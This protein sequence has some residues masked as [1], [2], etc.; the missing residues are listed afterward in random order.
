M[1]VTSGYVLEPPRVGGSNSTLTQTPNDLVSN[2][3]AFSASY[4]TSETVPRT[5]YMVLVM[6]DGKLPSAKFG[7][8]RNEG[9]LPLAP[10]VQ[11]FDYDARRQRFFPLPG[12]KPITVGVLSSN[13]N[14]QRL[15]VPVP[16][17][18]S[19]TAPVRLFFGSVGSG[20]TQ[21]VTLVESFGSPP[22]GTTEILTFGPNTGQ[23]NWNASDLITLGGLTVFFQQQ[24][25][26]SFSASNGNL[27]LLGNNTLL[28]N[29]IPGDTQYPLLRIGFGLWFQAVERSDD[30]HLSVNPASG[31][32]EWSAST[33]LL[34]FNAGDIT[35]NAGATVYYDGILIGANLSLPRQS[36]G[37]VNSQNNTSPQPI[38]I[39]NTPAVGGDVIFLIPGVIQFAQSVAV[40]VASFDSVGK[41]G[42]VQY[43]PTTGQ[44]ILSLADRTAYAGQPLQVVFGDLPIERGVSMRFFRTPIDLSG[45]N[46]T[47]KDVSCI[48]S[49]QSAVWQS[50]IIAMS[51]VAL[52]SVPIEDASFPVVVR[53]TQGTGSF[54]GTLPN[55][56]TVNP[57]AGLGYVFDFPNGQLDYAQRSNN[58][59]IPIQQSSSAVLLPNPLVVDSQ[60]SFGLETSPGSGLFFPFT[61]TPP[62][63]GVFTSGTG[64]GGLLNTTAGQFSF[65]QVVGVLLADGS[66]GS[67]SGASFSDP[68]QNFVAD[69]VQPGNAL[70]ALSGSSKGVYTVSGVSPT[71]LT[72][73]LPGGTTSS[74]PYEVVQGAEVLADRFFSQVELVD[75]N[76]RVEIIQSL[77][78]ISNAPRLS[79]QTSLVGSLRIRFGKGPLSTFS[80]AVNLVSN[81]GSFTT[82]S[83]LS[84]GVVEASISTGNL[85]FSSSDLVTGV[86]VYSVVRLVQDKD[87]TL[88]PALG[89]IS[90][91]QRFL[92]LQEGLVTYVSSEGPATPLVEPATFLVRKELAQPH[93][94]P[95]STVTFNPLGRTVFKVTGVFRGGRP[96]VI[97][98]QCI[99]DTAHATVTF[100]PDSQITNAL[101]HGATVQPNENIYIDYLILEAIGGENVLTVQNPPMSVATV[102]I[103]SGQSSFSISGNWVSSFIPG[104]LLRIEKEQVYILGSSTFDGPSNTTTVSIGGGETFTD[105]FSNPDLFVTSGLIRTSG[106]ALQP[107]YF[108]TEPSSYAPISRGMNTILLAGNRTSTYRTGSIL[109]FTDLAASF[110]DFY[111]STGVSFNATT[112]QTQ[113]TISRNTVRQYDTQ[114]LKFSIRPIIEASTSTVSTTLTPVQSQSL[115]VWRRTEGQIGTILS[116]PSDYTIDS[117]GNVTFGVPLQVNEALVIAYTGSIFVQG[118]L[119]FQASYTSLAAPSS[120][121]GLLNQSLTADY[122][123]F[124]PDSFYFRVESM[125]NFENEVSAD[126]QSQALQ[127]V[128]SGGPLLS[129]TSQPQLFQQGKPSIFF[130]EGHLAN[131]DTIARVVLKIYNDSINSLEGF[132]NNIDGRI[133]G[134]VDGAFSFD[135]VV[136]RV[137][138]GFPPTSIF[139]EIDDLIQV[140]PFPLPGGTFQQV[141]LPGPYSRFFP[142]RRNL[143]T[144]SP[145][146]A[147]V[148]NGDQIAK[149]TF[150]A[151]SSLPFSAFRRWPRAQIQASYPAGTST[152]LVDNATGTNDA[153]QRP[154][155]VNSMRV[156]V[157]DRSGNIYVA[158]AA[159]VTV[160]SFTATSITLS[161]PVGV[162]VPA[163]ATIYLAPSDT[164]YAA[165]FQNGRDFN[166]DL[167]SGEVL[168]QTSTNPIPSGDILQINGVG[169][170][171]SN[172]SPFKFP[173]LTGGTTTDDGDQTVPIAGPIFIGETTPGGG[174]PLNTELAAELNTSGT[175]RTNTTAPYVGTG[176]L[177]VTKTIIT[178]NS[179]S[180]PSPIPKVNDLVRVTSGLNGA[181]SFH[182][183][184]GVGANTVT[185]DS[186][187]S[188]QDSNF[189]YE[190]TVSSTTISGTATLTGTALHDGS[191][192]FTTN[193]TRV[194]YTVVIT[195]VGSDLG[196]RRQIVSITS[197]TD[198]VLNSAFPVNGTFTYRIDNSLAT[199]NGSDYTSVLSAIAQEIT[200]V[201]TFEI[202]NLL[203]F[204]STVFTELV[205]GTNGQTLGNQSQLTDTTVNFVASEV[206]ASDFVFIP[207]GPNTGVYPVSSVLDPH[208]LILKAPLPASQTNIGYQV[209]SS[210][211]I[212]LNTMNDVVGIITNNRT[213]VATTTIFQSLLTTQVPVN[214]GGSNDASAFALGVVL[215]DVNS[216]L[217]VVQ[218]RLAYLADAANGPVAKVQNAL[219]GNERLYDKR[220]TW[221]DA[222]IN[223]S[224]GFL[225]GQQRALANRIATQATILNQLTKLLAVGNG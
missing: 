15:S 102:S 69:G 135:G 16:L 129:N 163:G 41:Q 27:G 218:G 185:V 89:T 179:V 60:L 186:A 178:D 33:G 173:G 114:I 110:Q 125:T 116:T 126:L 32:V 122:S 93:P 209:V 194:G 108:L 131:E 181:T 195:G 99:V 18:I 45:T 165:T 182:R 204:F 183:I 136:G 161:S 148:S 35:N 150:S 57:P 224:S 74:V 26:F 118:G 65:T 70:L 120:Q 187:F 55:L 210:F 19:K 180:F 123:T 22:P 188:V 170:S 111:Q 63:S 71:S 189:S 141:Y 1:S 94:A 83:H 34:K 214:I 92:A 8:T 85:N 79:V 203:A 113:I 48:Y 151:I 174:G 43:D 31:T 24:S 112:N 29:P 205:L 101:P 127:S 192:L 5:D 9:F 156:V 53:V 196:F 11:R 106:T 28:L 72:T 7:F 39:L 142:T 197:N 207:S 139:N 193:G 68:S 121:N 25:S 56:R 64:I 169:L 6:S 104:T 103:T 86:T 42:Q 14:V 105:S 166:V 162:P 200:V 78:T 124:T 208:N 222:R 159:N 95:T 23:L 216:R 36:V 225:V 47:V 199:Y 167:P 132:L 172:I 212:G 52:P 100:L 75:P 37:T 138:S 46:L 44:F 30:A 171:I 88:T 61:E 82:P 155:F 21:I 211:G 107:S 206:S 140:S 12:G 160:S 115:I 73:D 134:D 90:F 96:Q 153:L 59:F 87:Y 50:P 109:L 149:L 201:G 67:F 66:S 157:A 76:T 98:T 80:S 51:Q 117:T 184:S 168:F 133:V 158:D 220:Y 219:T 4:P 144:T 215:T 128:P 198:L 164:V 177:D 3:A 91:T 191:G 146:F 84:A 213:F 119:R 223:Q 152:F 49:V 176:S 20:T 58:I 217:A 221:I 54:T 17:A 154:S 202:N 38:S 147:G 40:P 143:F 97:G 137:I 145:T 10:A 2:S 130:D 81:D 13:A 77:G 62:G 175:W 190:V